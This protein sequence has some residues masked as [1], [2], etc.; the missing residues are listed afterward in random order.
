MNKKRYEEIKQ[1]EQSLKGIAR[2]KFLVEELSEK[3]RL[4]YYEYKKFLEFQKEW[5]G[6]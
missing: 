4:E 1:K 6:M 5:I 2:F 3:E